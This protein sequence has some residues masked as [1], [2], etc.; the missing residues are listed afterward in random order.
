VAWRYSCT[1]LVCS[2]SELLGMYKHAAGDEAGRELPPLSFSYYG[3]I[4]VQ[5]TTGT[6]PGL[7]SAH[8]KSRRQTTDRWA[9]CCIEDGGRTVPV[10]QYEYTKGVASSNL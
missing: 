9:L 5:S 7:T 4:K 3:I 8:K 2:A 6:G 10:C 1:G